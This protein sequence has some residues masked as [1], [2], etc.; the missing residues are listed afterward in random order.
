MP[1]RLADVTEIHMG[2]E[3]E[4]PWEQYLWPLQNSNFIYTGP[5]TTNVTINP[6]EV[7]DTIDWLNDYINPWK[8]HEGITIMS[9]PKDEQLPE[10]DSEILMAAILGEQEVV[11]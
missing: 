2:T 6:D 8:D 3:P 9:E 11:D 7:N 1:I 4:S 10:I 5:T